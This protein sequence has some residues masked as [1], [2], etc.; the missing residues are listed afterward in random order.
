AAKGTC[1]LGRSPASLGAVYLGIFRWQ[2]LQG[3]TAFRS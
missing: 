2:K 3:A 1:P